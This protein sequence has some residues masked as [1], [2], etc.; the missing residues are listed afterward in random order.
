MCAF[1]IY[2][3]FL[4]RENALQQQLGFPKDAFNDFQKSTKKRGTEK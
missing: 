3:K 4:R 2:L 1:C